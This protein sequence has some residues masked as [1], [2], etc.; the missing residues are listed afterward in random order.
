MQVLKAASQCEQ[1]LEADANKSK[2]THIQK[3]KVMVK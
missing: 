1:K 2:M 3:Q